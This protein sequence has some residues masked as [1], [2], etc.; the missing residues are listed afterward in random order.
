MEDRQTET[1]YEF[2]FSAFSFKNIFTCIFIHSVYT[3]SS[4]IYKSQ[5][6]SADNGGVIKDEP[7]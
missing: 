2:L 5:H 1:G 7:M 4:R 6:F 3:P